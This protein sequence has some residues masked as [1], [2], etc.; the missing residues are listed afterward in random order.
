MVRGRIPSWPEIRVPRVLVVDDVAESRGLCR[1]VL[2]DAGYEVIEAGD[3]GEGVTLARGVQP[4]VVVMDLCM[5]QMDG[6]EAIRC[7]KADPRTASVPV[8]VLTGLGWQPS[9]ADGDFHAYL[10]KP[11]SPS[12][13]VG[14]LD[15]ILGRARPGTGRVDVGLAR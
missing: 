6:W 5:P 14:V 3:G 8:V 15:A 1:E 4:D 9:F 10:V 2:R 12:D 7:L 11:C 13:L